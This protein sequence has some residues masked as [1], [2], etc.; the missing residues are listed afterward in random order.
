MPL[1]LKLFNTNLDTG[2]IPEIWTIGIIM[3]IYKNKGDRNN[4]GSHRRI[5]LVS[6][7]LYQH[8]IEMT[9]KI[10]IANWYAVCQWCIFSFGHIIYVFWLHFWYLQTF[11]VRHSLQQTSSLTNTTQTETRRLLLH[12]LHTDDNQRGLKCLTVIFV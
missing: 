10:Q 2:I 4:P 9:H 12:C 3:Y 11:L 5:T 8:F 7:Q 1:Y 6:S